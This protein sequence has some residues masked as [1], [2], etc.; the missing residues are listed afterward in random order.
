M[1]YIEDNA[2]ATGETIVYTAVKSKIYLFWY[3]VAGILFCWLL[4]IPTIRAIKE[5][6][7]YKTTEYVVTDKK[8]VEK[9]GIMTTHCDEMRLDKI[10]NI[11][12][13]QTTGGKMFGYGN[14]CIQGT[15]RNNIHF[16]RVKNPAEVKKAINNLLP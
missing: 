1:G 5:S 16:N 8:V 14:V 15:K 13:N 11:T 2:F 12:I 10:E 4:L 9:Y 7:M 3:W 6:L